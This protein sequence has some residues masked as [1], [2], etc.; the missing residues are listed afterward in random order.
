MHHSQI[1][2]YL[3]Y[4]V[5]CHHVGKLSSFHHFFLNVEGPK[6]KKLPLLFLTLLKMCPSFSAEVWAALKDKTSSITWARHVVGVRDVRAQPPSFLPLAG[7]PYGGEA[8]YVR[9][10]SDAL[11]LQ[12][13]AAPELHDATR[14]QF[15][16]RSCP[17]VSSAFR[18][19]STEITRK[20]VDGYLGCATWRHDCT[21]TL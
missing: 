13:V 8:G 18:Q 11:T 15:L 17:F 20:Q 10:S 6:K 3:K 12:R 1:S 21:Q 9:Q 14:A 2:D 5:I 19:R 7:C 4:R 16:G